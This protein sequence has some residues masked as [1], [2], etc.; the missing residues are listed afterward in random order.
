MWIYIWDTEI[1]WMYLW[2]TPVKE[3]Y[4]W[5]TKIRPEDTRTFTISRT[6]GQVYSWCTY[7]DD[8]AWLTS[9]S[10]DFDEFF[11]YYW[12]RL[13][14]LWNETAKVTQ[15]ES[16]WAWNL[17]ITDLWTITSWDNV[18]IAF[19]KMWVKMTKNWSTVTLSLTKDKNK[20]WYQYYAFNRNWAIQNKF[21]LWA[22]KGYLSSSKIVSLSWKSPVWNS[23]IDTY[24][25]RC[26]AN[27][28][29]YW[30][31]T[32][33]QRWFVNA[34]YIMKYWN[35]N[36]QA[37]IWRWYTYS[38]SSKKNT[39]G[40]N[41]YTSASWWETGW[42]TQAKLFWLE[43]WWWNCNEYTDW[44]YVTPSKE[45]IVDT[46]N[47]PTSIASRPSSPWWNWISTWMQ[48]SSQPNW[49]IQQ[50]VWTND[51]MFMFT[52]AS[53]SGYSYYYWDY[54]IA[55]EYA[56]AACWWYKSGNYE[57]W[58]FCLSLIYTATSSDETSSRLMY[59]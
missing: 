48:Y 31:V 7:S 49:V 5:D 3:V 35:P 40:T 21:Y 9:G 37:T 18:M 46:S 33:W 55:G 20:S 59:L 47:N 27:G 42:K 56:V 12:C 13:N 53:G 58:P 36:A 51:W 22:Y 17:K 2:D 19:P 23:N 45:V 43:D 52:K 10:T 44:I 16:W 41:S 26:V 34:L 6:E 57:A 30:Q 15:W 54:W 38:N 28:T 29:N 8:A 14:Y 11:G 4:V 39:G 50:I 32:I 1:K 24:R 25:S